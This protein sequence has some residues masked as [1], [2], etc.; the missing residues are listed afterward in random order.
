MSWG[1]KP[2]AMIGHSVGE[3]VAAALAGV[4]SL[5]A[6]LGIVAA[7]GRL[8]QDLP[9]GAMLA[10][11]LPEAEVL[12]LLTPG[13]AIA[14]INGPALCV[15]SGPYG[16]VDALEK[17]L[18]GRNVVNRRLHTSHAFHSAM[19][20]PM[21][22]PLRAH[23]QSVRLS[24]PSIPYVSCVTGDWI[25][26]EEATS[27]GYWARHAREPVRFAD[28]VMK[29]GDLPSAALLEV[30][31]GATLSA[32]AAQAMRGRSV[33]VIASM[34][35]A[36]RER[37]DRECLLEALGRL[38][39]HGAT[40]DWQAVHGAPRARVSLPS[41][42]FE[43]KRH[44][45]EPPKIAAGAES[46]ATT[47]ARDEP[48]QMTGVD[49]PPLLT[50]Q[51]DSTMEQRPVDNRISDISGMVAAIIE[52]LSG[53]RPAATDARTTF[54]EM[55]Y[56]SLFL[57]QVA[58]K[59]QSQM[60]VKITFRQLLGDFSTIPALAKFL[61]EKMPPAPKPA[62]AKP[63][64]PP[65]A[66]I[67]VAAAPQ[68]ALQGTPA[69]AGVEGI[70]RDQLQAMSQ[71][72]NR[73]FEMLQG[74]GAGAAPAV[75]AAMQPRSAHRNPQRHRNR[76]RLP[77]PRRPRPHLPPMGRSRRASPSSCRFRNR[78]IRAS[79]PNSA[80]TSRRWSPAT[81]QKTSGSR[82]FTQAHRPTLADPRA[83]AGFRSEWK[84]MVYPIVVA[85]AGGSKLLDVDGNE[86]IDLVNGFGQTALGHSPPFVVEA[87]KA[88]L[89]RGF[90]IGPQAELAGKVADLFCEMT[91]N[92]RMTF[93][94]TGSEAVMAAMRIARTVTGRQ[95]IV[96]FN[97]DYHGQFDEVLVKGVQR[98]GGE[99]RSVPVA[100]GIPGSAVENM[101]VLE[102]GS[103]QSLQWI[104]DNADDL[105]AV[106]VEP[107]QSRHADLRPFDF[108]REVR[109]ITAAS[110]TAF[111]MDEVVTGFRVHPGG[112]QAVIGIRADMATYGKVVGG[113]LPI[114]VLAGNSRF[115]D[116]L[117]G[118]QWRFGDDSVPEAGVTF[119]AGTFV[120]HPLVLAAAWAVLNHLKDHGPALQETLA[121]KTLALVERLRAL[122]AH[123]GLAAR[124]E[125][126]SSWFFFHLH[127]DHPL[128]ALLFYHLRER[129]IHI[130]DGFP[131]FLTT[132]HS[133]ADFERIYAAFE[134]SLEELQSVGIVG[135]ALAQGD[136][137]PARVAAAAGPAAADAVP[138]TES[139]LEIW[140][141]AQLGDEA[142]CA[143]NESVSLGLRGELNA[144]ALQSALNRV[145]ARHDAL[146]ARFS[147]TGEEM[148]I[149]GAG[150]GRLPVHRPVRRHRSAGRGGLRQAARRRCP[151][152]LRPGRGSLPA[153][154]LGQA[155]RRSACV[156]ADRAPHHLRWLVAERDR[157]RTRGD[158]CRALP[159]RG[160][161]AAGADGIQRVRALAGR[162]RPGGTREDRTLL[163]GPV[164]GTPDD[165]SSCP[166]I[167]PGP[168]SSPSRG[169]ACAAASMPSSIR[170]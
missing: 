137:P 7:R 82:S 69:P 70:F 94:N 136:A 2:R 83:A 128:T 52:D 41:Y 155:R 62:A 123:H 115:M 71:L 57:T 118:G 125:S 10:V 15:V 18:T 93:C 131:C 20:D 66:A 79:P 129:G 80:S 143:F 104:R 46:G 21:I 40:P 30:G 96:I 78:A 101:I 102:Y 85:N 103:D 14:A 169:R 149:A 36:A 95:K 5:E 91:G 144:A 19:V 45:I 89:D 54:L 138:L 58:Q 98:P 116:A 44:W 163:D 127:N 121:R 159:R 168:P 33:S 81:R 108:L 6:A 3:F 9:G 42:P 139:Q 72:I 26:A 141:A 130:Q 35:D 32:L 73:Q 31:P 64:A 65:P 27:P 77:R 55:G 165:R 87:V 122:F 11:R 135:P 106:I 107:V 48:P 22:E 150:A 49:E 13:L 59:I 119:F 117:D 8:M 164:R 68:A 51:I 152:A 97:G 67:R 160:T 156:R 158:L 146:R 133:D 50:N 170:R 24:A 12:Q 17:A 161:A 39:I 109:R 86:Y 153:R 38:W 134:E 140:L 74:L 142:S 147:A 29:L 23:L 154:A 114:G 76:R 126:Y 56:D 110:G 120:R 25:R 113:G 148:R 166:P 16:E 1:I 61:A 90:A 112:M 124:I 63:A 53:E 167:G 4:F 34:Q 145:V 47:E 88:Q 162:A 60:K 151:H 99:P 132:A 84:D 28:G 37:S 157:D 105:A 75:P 43:R 92:E 111:V 100:P